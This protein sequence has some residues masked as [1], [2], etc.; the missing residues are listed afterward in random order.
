LSIRSIHLYKCL[1]LTIIQYNLTYLLF[2]ILLSFFS[3]LYLFILYFFS[4]LYSLTSYLLYPPH[5]F[6]AYSFIHSLIHISILHSLSI[7]FSTIFIILPSNTFSL[8]LPFFTLFPSCFHS[9]TSFSGPFKDTVLPSVE[10][11][12]HGAPKTLK[13][14]M[15]KLPHAYVPRYLRLKEQ[16]ISLST[17]FLFLFTLPCSL[18]FFCLFF[19]HPS[20][21][22]SNLLYF[23]PS[24]FSPSLSVTLFYFIFY[25]FSSLSLT[26]FLLF[27][28]LFHTSFCHPF[29]LTFLI[30]SYSN[31][32]YNVL[33]IAFIQFN[34][35][36]LHTLMIFI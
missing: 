27:L 24:C 23:P 34:T 9:I 26:F 18:F 19:I 7:A 3:F 1:V 12:I 33:I 20:L 29:I 22:L 6:T 21:T 28:R 14:A 17:L 15:L 8:S 36:L 4:S 25:T 10:S 5:F 31:L 16:N 2:P 11:R 30:L 35:F 13:H 32:A